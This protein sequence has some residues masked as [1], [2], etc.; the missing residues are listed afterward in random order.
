[1]QGIGCRDYSTSQD[2]YNRVYRLLGYFDSRYP[3]CSRVLSDWQLTPY[4]ST[5]AGCFSALDIRLT[6]EYAI[7]QLTPSIER[8]KCAVFQGTP[9][10]EC[11]KYRAFNDTPSSGVRKHPEFQNEKEYRIPGM[12]SISGCPRNQRNEIHVPHP[13]LSTFGAFGVFVTVF[14]PFFL[15]GCLGWK[16]SSSLPSPASLSP[17]SCAEASGYDQKTSVRIIPGREGGEGVLMIL[18]ATVS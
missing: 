1:M 14:F 3:G 16:T 13:T 17:S 15:G 6:V 2:K 18:H 10:I 11:T 9:D 7:F 12:L 4:L 5:N 8:R